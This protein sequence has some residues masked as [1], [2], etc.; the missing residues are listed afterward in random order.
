MNATTKQAPLFYYNGIK[1]Q[2]GAKLQKCHY[3]GGPYTTLP[4]GT[5]T[6]YARNYARFSS[7]VADWFTVENG[8]DIQTDYF[9]N[10]R[11][12]VTPNHPL[13][14]AV[15]AALDAQTARHEKRY[16]RA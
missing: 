12:R 8:T 15:K 14:P 16:G 5:I 7:M 4:A 3:S 6:I 11:I 1:E 13:Y 9:E 10:D 2:K